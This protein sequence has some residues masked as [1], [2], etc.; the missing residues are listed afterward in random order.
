MVKNLDFVSIFYREEVVSKNWYLVS[1]FSLD[2]AFLFRVQYML[3]Y[4]EIS[5]LLVN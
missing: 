1:S 3:H 5:F 4:G 2:F